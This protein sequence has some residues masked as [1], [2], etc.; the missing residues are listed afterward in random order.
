MP[1]ESE[2]AVG[3]TELARKVRTQTFWFSF[4]KFLATFIAVVRPD[5]P[6]VAIYF[7]KQPLARKAFEA[8]ITTA[9][10]FA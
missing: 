5:A 6:Q 2:G 1:E 3:S 4:K 9:S 7:D 8:T 10:A